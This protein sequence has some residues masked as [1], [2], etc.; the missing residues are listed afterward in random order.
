MSA[1]MGVCVVHMC[2][3]VCVHVCIVHVCK[4]VCEDV[5]AHVETYF[6]VFWSDTVKQ[7]GGY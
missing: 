4:Y 7:K 5:H 2:K 3:G 6:T 1:G